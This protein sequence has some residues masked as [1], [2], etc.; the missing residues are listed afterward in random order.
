MSPRETIA[1]RDRQT[2]NNVA[3]RQ[4]GSG[5]T[6]YIGLINRLKGAGVAIRHVPPRRAQCLEIGLAVLDEGFMEQILGM[7]LR[8]NPMI[9]LDISQVHPKEGDRG[10]PLALGGSTSRPIWPY[11]PICRT[12][13]CEG[14]R[15][16]LRTNSAASV[17][18]PID[19]SGSNYCPSCGR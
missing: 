10:K 14:I 17:S 19:L 12:W 6:W 13:R 18:S 3:R 16:R 7:T 1:S 9:R 2:T 11:A 4:H 8:H 15:K 5:T